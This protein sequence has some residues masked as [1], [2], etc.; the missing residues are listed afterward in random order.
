M[1]LHRS[2]LYCQVIRSIK[3]P[4]SL[5]PDKTLYE[6]R[7]TK[8]PDELPPII[9]L[10]ENLP[11]FFLRPSSDRIPWHTTLFLS[12]NASDLEPTYALHSLDPDLPASRN[13]YS[14]ALLD[15]HNPSVIFAE[16]LSR[17]QWSQPTAEELRLQGANPSPPKP[18][19]PDIFTLQLY[20]PDQQ[21]QVVY[22]EGKWSS[23]SYWEFDLPIQ[24]FRTPSTSAIDKA[25][26]DPS[27]S[28]ITPKLTFKWR[29]EGRLSKDLVC[30][31][32][33]KGNLQRT[34]RSDREPEITIAIFKS[35]KELIIYEPNLSRVEMEDLK[36]L[37]IVVLLSAAAIRDIFFGDMAQV[38]HI[39]D[40]A[41]RK[42]SNCSARKNSSPSIPII[43]GPSASVF[44]TPPHPANPP[45]NQRLT[46]PS[47]Q[48]PS[49]R[50]LQPP[51]PPRPQPPHDPEAAARHRAHQAAEVERLKAE[52][53]ASRRRIEK[54]QK[55]DLRIKREEEREA[56]RRAV[57]NEREARRIQQEYEAEQRRGQQPGRRPPVNTSSNPGLPPRPHSAQPGHRPHQHQHQSSS[58][59]RPQGPPQMHRPNPQSAYTAPVPQVHFPPAFGL[60][61]SVPY[62]PA[63]RQNHVP[64]P[65]PPQQHSQPLPQQAVSGGGVWSNLLNVGS[66]GDVLFGSGHHSTG[67]QFAKPLKTKRS[68]LF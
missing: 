40:A 27:A 14:I 1:V 56:R 68:S 58:Y 41:P 4:P 23:P 34:K 54:I 2:T 67:H 30:S 33:S 59:N 53:K 11:T 52:E 62:A 35:F 8:V 46:K 25:H 38:F 49:P 31:L 39:S 60:P 9:M 47:A 55:E 63:P 3:L 51:Q 61:P 29:K 44:P 19:W 7:C 37:E 36:G 6:R 16:I 12:A 57:E 18:I 28:A 17:L 22:H 24:S 64:R 20:N 65:P 10:D 32:S 13:T 43:P 48:N 15:A 42:G 50:P 5:L 26:D 66:L 21:V 45:P